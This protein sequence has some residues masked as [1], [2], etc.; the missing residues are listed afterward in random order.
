APHPGVTTMWSGTIGHWAW[1]TE[2]THVPEQGLSARAYRVASR[3]GVGLASALAIGLSVGLLVGYASTA[4]GAAAAGRRVGD[5]FFTAHSRILHNDA[6]VASF[7]L[8]ATLAGWRAGEVS[9]RARVGWWVLGAVAVALSSLS[10]LTGAVGLLPLFGPT[11][12]AAWGE[13]GGTPLV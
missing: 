1:M 5:T 3:R 4:L 6:L 13:A 11:L 8:V 10:K 7:F 9:G 12:W 2:H